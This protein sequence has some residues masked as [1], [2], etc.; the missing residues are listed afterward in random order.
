VLSCFELSGIVVEFILSVQP[1]NNVIAKSSMMQI[2]FLK[3]E[4]TPFI[5]FNKLSEID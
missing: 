3:I 4:I 1:H 5:S 2:D